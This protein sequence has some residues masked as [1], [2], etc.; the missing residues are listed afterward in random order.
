MRYRERAG[1][2]CGVA[3]SGNVAWLL[4]ALLVAAAVSIGAQDKAATQMGQQAPA[5]AGASVA[6]QTVMPDSAANAAVAK[7]SVAEAVELTRRAQASTNI[8]EKQASLQRAEAIYTSA[9]QADPKQGAALNNLAVLAVG[10]GDGTT[11]QQYF[12]RAIAADDGHKALYALNY[13]K[14]LQTTD[15]PAAIKAARVAVAAAPDSTIANEQ[16]G[17][18]LWKTN[19]AEMLP[20]ADD[21]LSRGHTEL[22]TR[23]A[24]QCLTS[25]TRPA[26]ERRAW[27]IL[28][29]SR[30]AREYGLSDLARES[31]SN[32]LGKV[33]ADPE[34]GRGSRQLR[35]VIVTPPQSSADIDW[36][37]GQMQP[38]L[39]QHASGRSAMRNVLLAAGEFASQRDT[40]RA[41]QYFTAAIDLGDKGPDPDAFLRLVE[42]YASTGAGEELAKATQELAALMDRYQNAMFQE[43]SGAYRTENWEL[44]YR[45]HVALGMTYAYLQVWRSEVPYQNAIFQLSHAMQ[46]AERANSQRRDGGKP[47][48]LPPVGIE[49]LAQGY[50]AIGRKDLALRAR[51]E[52]STALMKVRHVQDSAEVFH[53]IPSADIQLLD[54]GSRAKYEALRTATTL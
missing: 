27:L 24:L 3:R 29:A 50:V 14:Y 2:P 41:A 46:A 15:K 32:D 31:I 42:L 44:I 16:L 28:V 17:S 10:K 11:A 49:K 35:A 40:K 4:G 30:L 21:L 8:A 51:I 22:A 26:A 45:M 34:V 48:A 39:G 43:K 13:S 6:K 47:L 7:G 37:A 36:W 12:E 1:S 53:S 20:L 5:A 9:L 23:F 54:E 38:A 18:L 25:Q 19:P 52:G 33:E